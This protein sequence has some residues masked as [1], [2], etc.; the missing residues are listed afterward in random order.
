MKK[1]EI[2]KVLT[3]L[4]SALAVITVMILPARAEGEEY[5]TYSFYEP[6]KEETGVE[7]GE[8]NGE[9]NGEEKE[10]EAE[11]ND[12]QSQLAMIDY[13]LS[14]D[15][16]TAGAPVSERPAVKE[17]EHTMIFDYTESTVL[18]G[19]FGQSAYFFKIAKYWQIDYALAQIEYSISPMIDNVPASITFFINNSPIYSCAV[20]YERGATQIAYV[21]IPTEL[22][23]E[24]YNNFTISGFV[25]LYDDDGCLDDLSGANW[26]SI[27]KNSFIEVGYSVMDT[28]YQISY[29]PYPLISTMDETGEHLNVYVPEN[30]SE[31]ELRAAFM[32]RADLGDETVRE[33][34]IGFLTFSH[35]TAGKNALF[36]ASRDH[37]PET[38][39]SRMPS[40]SRDLAGGALVYEYGE[41]DTAILV[42]TSED[43]ECLAEGAALLMGVDRVTQEKA[44]WAYVPKG[45]S[46]Q[47]IMNR[48]LS[49]LIEDGETIKGITDYDGL[50]FIG[51]FHQEQTIYLPFSGG[52]ILGEGGKID[53]RLRYSDNLDFDRSL[54]TVY[55]GDKPVASKKLDREKCDSDVFSFMMPS[56]AVGTHAA[57]IKIAYDLEVKDQYCTR[58]ADEMPWGYV[59]GDSVLYLPVGASS[60]YDLSLRPYPF[61]QLGSFN[62]LAVVVPDSMS[63]AELSLFGRIAALLG[64]NVS[65]YGDLL[66]FKA[67]SYPAES[68][69]RHVVTLGTYR[70]NA[71]IQKINEH[72]SFRYSSDGG[73]FLSNDQL[74]LG[75]RFSREMG[76]L[77][78]IRSPWQKSRAILAVSGTEDAS[79]NAIERFASVQEN[80]WTLAGD[81]FL[82]DR[83]LETKHY[84]FLKDEAVHQASLRERIAQNKDAILFTLVSTLAMILILAAVLIVVFRYRKNKAE[85]EKK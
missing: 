2:G 43:P 11:R 63:D 45:S 47:V 18:R 3:T 30:A 84:R 66:V 46:E 68:E 44:D 12:S 65:P 61:Q 72:L 40:V 24:G 5:E 78:I 17:S 81:A 53:L 42:L 29:Y 21:L 35:Y 77:Q 14:G 22:L 34:D 85:E 38:I 32:L 50:S 59:S 27:S 36:V 6:G 16:E 55:W 1:K 19:V 10:A 83:D 9:V 26:I 20:N 8:E 71:F 58:R 37:L 15:P 70:S 64:A 79:L 67:S 57:S 49:A 80:N 69:N 39:R 13:V 33:D 56:D 52:F 7:T 82:I 41:G 75:D 23:E 25:R 51:P 73:S 62:H 74:L 31:E 60:T 48:S 76:V 28:G 4:L 54:I